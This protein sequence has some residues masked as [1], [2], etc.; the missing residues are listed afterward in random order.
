MYEWLRLTFS[1]SPTREDSPLSKLHLKKEA[2]PCSETLWLLISDDIQNFSRDHETPCFA[3][4][5]LNVGV[6]GIQARK[7]A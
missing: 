1:K 7:S 2:D 5:S 3:V 4:C 6:L